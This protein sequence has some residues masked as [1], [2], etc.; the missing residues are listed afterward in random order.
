MKSITSK[1]VWLSLLSL[2][3]MATGCARPRYVHAVFFS[4]KEGT[5]PA[6]M[7]ALASDSIEQLSKIPSVRKIASGPRDAQ[8]L[9]EVNVADFDI[10]LV[11]YFDDKAGYDLYENHPI[12]EQYVQKYRSSWAQVRVFDFIAK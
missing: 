5:P 10:G 7:E 8:A 4:F 11:V 6:E 3:V 1:I 9:R 12:H 2:I